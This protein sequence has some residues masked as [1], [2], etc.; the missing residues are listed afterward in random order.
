[1]RDALGSFSD[2]R[3]QSL[4]GWEFCRARGELKI[5]FKSIPGC[6]LFGRVELDPG[7]RHWFHFS[8]NRVVKKEKTGRPF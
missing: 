7:T 1:M 3:V 8:Y 2:G 4:N 5:T 6:A